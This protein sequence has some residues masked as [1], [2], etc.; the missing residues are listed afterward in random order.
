MQL[1]VG[2]MDENEGTHQ[3]THPIAVVNNK[4]KGKA[5][6]IAPLKRSQHLAYESCLFVRLTLNY[7]FSVV[8]LPWA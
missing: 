1:Q 4:G 6:A 3:D 2:A 7:F 8:F 5:K